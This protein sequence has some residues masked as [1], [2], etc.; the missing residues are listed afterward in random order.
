MRRGCAKLSTFAG[1]LTASTGGPRIRRKERSPTSER[2]LKGT[3]ADASATARR[4]ELLM[5]VTSLTPP[6][7]TRSS[8]MVL[9]F[10][11]MWLATLVGAIYGS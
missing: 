3:P 2:T 5:L 11:L 10:A 1:G 6:P 9:I 7:A 4:R 8:V